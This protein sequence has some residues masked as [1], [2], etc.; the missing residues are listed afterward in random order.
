VDLELSDDPDGLAE[1]VVSYFA[2]KYVVDRFLATKQSALAIFLMA[3]SNRKELDKES[4]ETLSRLAVR[5]EQ[6]Y[7]TDTSSEYEAFDEA[8][9]LEIHY[10]GNP[11]DL[12]SF[13]TFHW[14]LQEI[15]SDVALQLLIQFDNVYPTSWMRRWNDEVARRHVRSEI[16]ELKTGSIDEIVF[17]VVGVLTQPDIRSILQNLAANIVW[18]IG[19]NRLSEVKSQSSSKSTKSQPVD[20]GFPLTKLDIGKNVKD[21][22]KVVAENNRTGTARVTFK[23]RTL[24]GESTEVTLIIEPEKK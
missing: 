23:H 13:A 18:V 20:T 6:Q 10:F 8:G 11:L 22:M 1:H 21:L 2:D 14:I 4:S 19:N 17:F 16:R 7:P 12:Y 9:T 3:L 24:S 5:I 15:V